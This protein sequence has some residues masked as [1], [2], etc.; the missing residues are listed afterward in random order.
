MKGDNDSWCTQLEDFAAFCEAVEIEGLD[1]DTASNASSRI[2]C[3]VAFTDT[4]DSTPERSDTEW[5]E[6]L[7]H[8]ERTPGGRQE[9]RSGLQHAWPPSLSVWCNPPYSNPASW[10]ACMMVHWL[11]FGRGIMLLPNYGLDTAWGQA[12]LAMI[13]YSNPAEDARDKGLVAHNLC[14]AILALC[15]TRFCAPYPAE[16]LRAFADEN[17][18]RDLW[19]EGLFARVWVPRGRLAFM[20]PDTLQVVPNNRGGSMV[21]YWGFG[22]VAP[23]GDGVLL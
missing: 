18:L 14:K 11:Q 9:P 4:S 12:V 8:V 15:D 19:A 17:V 23:L 3:R 10:V 22:A 1:L 21:V 5:A 7:V 13:A 20:D 16:R 2:L 6:L